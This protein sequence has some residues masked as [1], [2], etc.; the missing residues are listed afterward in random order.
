MSESERP[1]KNDKE[2]TT[3][4]V[5]RNAHVSTLTGVLDFKGGTEISDA[6]LIGLAKFHGVELVPIPVA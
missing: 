4:I 5:R 2:P 1:R 6:H 3:Y